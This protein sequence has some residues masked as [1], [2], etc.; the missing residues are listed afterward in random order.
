MSKSF[1]RMLHVSI[2]LQDIN[3]N[4][5]AFH[6]DSLSLQL[7]ESSP[8]GTVLA[9]PA[10]EDADSG[11]NGLLSYGFT[12]N[13]SGRVELRVVE[14]GQEGEASELRLVVVQPLDRELAD[15]YVVTVTAEDAGEGDQAAPRLSGQLVVLL[16]VLDANDNSPRFDQNL[17]Q[18]SV[19]EDLRAGSIILQVDCSTAIVPIKRIVIDR[20]RAFVHV[21]T[22]CSLYSLLCVRACISV[23]LYTLYRIQ[24]SAP[25]DQKNRPL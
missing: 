22:P 11:L 4:A 17:Y 24:N 18:A 1:Y 20:F 14:G 3:D 23:H 13:C 25:P 8:V 2:T 21:Y 9:L 12:C 15:L 19:R 5:P 7:I 6:P 16:T 10:A